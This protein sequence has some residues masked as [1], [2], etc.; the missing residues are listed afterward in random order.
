MFSFL[1]GLI[2]SLH[3]TSIYI[4]AS[5]IHFVSLDMVF[6]TVKVPVAVNSHYMNHQ[7]P[8]FQLKKKKKKRPEDK[9]TTNFR[10]WVNY[11]FKFICMHFDSL[12]LILGSLM[13]KYFGNVNTFQFL[14]WSRRPRI[15]SSSEKQHCTVL[16]ADVGVWLFSLKG[17]TTEDACG[18]VTAFWG[19]TRSVRGW[20]GYRV[21][22]YSPMSIP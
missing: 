10:F 12:Y 21:N 2:V 8:Q 20:T 15:T 9:F 17:W 5:G 4:G 1:L 6:L 3:K 7:G 19:E 11:T 14:I 13:V 22:T 16:L 18:S